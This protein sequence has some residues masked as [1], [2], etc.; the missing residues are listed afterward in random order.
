M[1]AVLAAPNP[2]PKIEPVQDILLLDESVSDSVAD[3]SSEPEPFVEP[4]EVRRTPRPAP[5]VAP[6][7][8]REKTPPEPVPAP[9]PVIEPVPAPVEPE[10]DPNQSP[11]PRSKKMAKI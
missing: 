11:S 7:P 5:I 6:S 8:P 1:L 2:K 9:E 3:E 10:I 4:E